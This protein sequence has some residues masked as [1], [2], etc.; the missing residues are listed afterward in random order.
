MT[1]YASMVGDADGDSD[2]DPEDYA[3][4]EVNFFPTT[5]VTCTKETQ[6]V[7]YL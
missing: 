1:F 4:F 6:M 3:L 2:P 5:T 7:D